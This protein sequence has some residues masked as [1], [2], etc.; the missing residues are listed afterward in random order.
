[1]GNG[2]AL[3]TTVP[4]VAPDISDRRTAAIEFD[5]LGEVGLSEPKAADVAGLEGERHE[6]IGDPSHFIQTAAPIGP[7]MQRQHRERGVEGLVSEGQPFSQRLN[8]RR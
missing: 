4:Q 7:M 6:T 2:D 1:M 5:D 3:H 8:Q